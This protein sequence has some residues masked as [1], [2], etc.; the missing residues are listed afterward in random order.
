MC[1]PR[2]KING[3]TLRCVSIHV[4]AVA[5]AHFLLC[6]LST[7]TSAAP[8]TVSKV[9]HPFDPDWPDVWLILAQK[10]NACHRSGSERIDLTAWEVFIDA[11]SSGD[12]LIVPG[13]PEQ[14]VLWQQVAWNYREEPGTKLPDE[15]LMPLDRNDWLTGKQQE[16]LARWIRNGA[17]KYRLPETCSTRPLMEIDYPSAKE[18]STCHPKQYTEW[19]RS[20]H[21]YAQHS[22]IFEAFNLT[23]Q[24]RTHGTIGTFCTRCHTPLGTALGE[25]GHRRNVHRSRLSMEGITCVACHR[26]ERPY[27]KASTRR[28]VI[29]GKLVEGCMYGP[30]SDSVA[31]KEDAHATAG[32][33]SIRTSAF[34]GSCHDVTSPEGIRLE[35]AYSEWQNSPAAADG[36]TCQHCHMGPVQGVPFFEH[37]RPL[38]RAAQV[39]GVDP[40][41]IPLRPLSDHTFSGPDYSVLPD[42]EFPY[43]LDWMYEKDYRKVSLLTNYEKNTL[44]DLRRRNRHQLR[45]ARDKRYE[46]LRNGAE[47][48]VELPP[49]VRPGEKTAVQVAVRSRFPGHNF[50]TG[51]TEER[52]F[53]VYVEV[54][55]ARGQYVFRSGDFDHNQDLRDGHSHEVESGR[56]SWD[57]HLLNFQSQFVALTNRGTERSVILSVNRHL[58]PL[59]VFR[60]SAGIPA[61]FGHPEPFRISK[62]SLPPLS[63]VHRKY[64]VE[65]PLQSGEYPVRVQLL[66]RHIPPHLM[67]EIGL[68]QLKHLLETVVLDEFKSIITVSGDRTVRLTDHGGGLLRR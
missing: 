30:F 14:S 33:A 63:T 43:K 56:I 20:M 31:A 58:A 51:F 15:P 23:L 2:H 5:A 59:N 34:C 19:S 46:L 41:Q 7:I 45:I 18:C 47:L 67:D 36:I 25:N 37:Q 64:P 32:L 13:N 29:P 26:V 44:D 6:S 61:A 27:Y 9:E 12:R 38:G 42:T 16:T 3:Q 65:L 28:H 11:D 40:E 39:P 53:W 60:P 55:D 1:R 21:A 66:Y 54:V 4:L 35:E 48:C 49:S 10:C 50:P 57:R 68:P 22:P 24:E 17:L 8:H 62:G 52:Q